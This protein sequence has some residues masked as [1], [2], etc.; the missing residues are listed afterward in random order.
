MH[1]KFYCIL[2]EEESFVVSLFQ[3]VYTYHILLQILWP[4]FDSCKLHIL[5]HNHSHISLNHVRFFLH[6]RYRAWIRLVKNL[7]SRNFG[8]SDSPCLWFINRYVIP[9]LVE[10]SLNNNCWTIKNA[11]LN[12]FAFILLMILLLIHVTSSGERERTVPQQN[13]QNILS[14]TCK[15]W[16]QQSWIRYTY[17]YWYFFFISLSMISIDTIADISTR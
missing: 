17:M 7:F 15:I 10:A 12:V 9:W 6:N 4:C 14:F 8:S 3:S 5:Y 11:T 16:H 13:L 1:R 2:I